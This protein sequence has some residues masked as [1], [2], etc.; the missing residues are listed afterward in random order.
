MSS[1]IENVKSFLEKQS[2]LNKP[3][4]EKAAADNG[5]T[6]QTKKRTIKRGKG[7]NKDLMSVSS[8]N[9]RGSSPPK[10]K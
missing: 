10:K 7:D 1:K 5:P 6:K 4:D 8:K 9:S 2:Y 3:I